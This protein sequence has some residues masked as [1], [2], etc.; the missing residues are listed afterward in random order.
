[1]WVAVAMAVASAAAQAYANNK[2]NKAE[3]DAIGRELEYNGLL[4]AEEERKTEETKKQIR[5]KENDLYS[6]IRGMNAIGNVDIN[7][8]GSAQD[9]FDIADKASADIEEL[10]HQM[11]VQRMLYA[12]TGETK[13]AASE[14][15]ATK[16][17]IETATL[18][19]DTGYKIKSLTDKP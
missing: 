8:V 18:A 10:N 13:A 3:R 5:R 9:Y 4:L 17:R 14:Y 2:K 7:G 11:N 12:K 1:M 16:S 19:L 6:R 15:I